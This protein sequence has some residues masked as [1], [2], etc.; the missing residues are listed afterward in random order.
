MIES[1]NV[2]LFISD[3]DICENDISILKSGYDN[4]G[5]N[6]QYKIIWIPIMEEWMQSKFENLRSKIPSTWYLLQNFKFKLGIKYIKEKWQ[7]KNRP[8]VVVMSLQGNVIHPNA[9]YM[10]SLGINPLFADSKPL[11]PPGEDSAGRLLFDKFNQ[12]RAT[13]VKFL[14]PIWLHDTLYITGF[15][16]LFRSI[17]QIYD[18]RILKIFNLLLL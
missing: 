15:V 1:K 14:S 13:W 4:M 6:D 17:I 10:I 16:L 11:Q 9:Y 2:F 3:L 8:I 5:K 7:F 18:P 12:D